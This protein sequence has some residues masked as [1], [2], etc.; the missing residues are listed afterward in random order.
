MFES[1]QR[2][3]LRKKQQNELSTKYKEETMF[4]TNYNKN[5]FRVHEKAMNF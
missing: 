5:I 3:Y 4:N 2:K 1:K